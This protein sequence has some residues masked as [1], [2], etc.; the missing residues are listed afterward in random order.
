M[1][2]LW[3]TSLIT[4]V[5][6]A[7]I[8]MDSEKL[9]MDIKAH[10]AINNEAIKQLNDTDLR[11]T[12]SAN[13]L[14]RHDNRIY[15]LETRNLWLRVLQYKHDHILSGHFSQ[16][17]T[18]ASV[19]HEYT[20]P[21]LWNFVIKFCEPCTTCMHSKSQRHHPYGLLKQ[22]LIPEQPWNS[23]SMDFIEQL[24]KSSGYTTILV[25]VDR[26]MKQAIF[27]PTHNTVTSANL[28]KLFIL[29]VF[30]KHGVPSHVPSDH[31][32]EFISHFFRYLGKALDM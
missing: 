24:L 17:K 27:I 15:I 23:I 8:T 29:H 26:L 22:L 13:G 7:S 18:L 5:L 11:W 21:G 28:A 9:L 1:E 12:Q 20:W 19:W 10:Q 25:V 6:Q 16:N 2:S 30:S 4:P 31:G 3:A 32:S 14:L